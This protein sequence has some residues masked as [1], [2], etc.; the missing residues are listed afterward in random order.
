MSGRDVPELYRGI[1][2]SASKSRANAVKLF[3]LECVGYVRTDV[4]GCT[5]TQCPLWTWRPYQ[6][7]A[8]TPGKTRTE[9]VQNA[10]TGDGRYLPS[11][12]P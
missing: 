12:K 6:A 10:R 3:C 7:K 8:P 5:A 4:T 11:Q 9:A 1:A 2:A